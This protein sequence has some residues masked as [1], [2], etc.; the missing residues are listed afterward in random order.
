MSSFSFLSFQYDDAFC[1]SSHTS[2]TP[3]DPNRMEF[4]CSQFSLICGIKGF[5]RVYE[6]ALRYRHMI[7]EKALERVR[8]LAFWEKYG[9]NTALDAFPKTKR[10]VLFLWKKNFHEGGKKL[11]SSLKRS[12]HQ[13][14]NENEY[15][16]PSSWK[17]YAAYEKNIPISEKTSSILCFSIFAMKEI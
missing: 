2:C 8:I 5:R 10:R 16:T 11:M 15:G 6:D 4:L 3:Y 17:K 14:Q 13:K 1:T 7:T 12:G 9:L